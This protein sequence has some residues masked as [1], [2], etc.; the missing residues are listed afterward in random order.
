MSEHS[1]EA[2]RGPRER[3]T[4]FAVGVVVILV[5]DFAVRLWSVSRW[6]WMLDDW[7]YMD[8]ASTMGLV[9]YLFQNYNGHIMPGE[10]LLVRVL[11]AIAPLDHGV[12]VDV[13]A[14]GATAAAAVWAV[15]LRELC[16]P[17]LRTLVPLALVTLTPIQLQATIWWAAALQ[18][19]SIQ[20][21]LGGCVYFATR[22][23]RDGRTRDRVGLLL[24]FAAGLLMWEKVLLL[25]IP[26]AVLLVYLAPAVPG[27][28]RRLGRE[29]GLLAAVAA[30]YAVLFLVLTL[31]PPN[32]ANPT[33][34]SWPTWDVVARWYGRLVG[35]LLSPGLLGG[36][37]GSL[38][39]AADVQASPPGWQVVAATALVAGGVVLAVRRCRAAWLPLVMVLVYAVASWGLVVAT[40]LDVLGLT[41]V[42][43][44]R[45]AIDTFMVLCLAVAMLLS[46]EAARVREPVAGSPGSEGRRGTALE[47]VL[48]VA[49]L[50][51]LV[52]A[53]VA[54]VQRIGTAPAKPWLDAVLEELDGLD[55]A[56]IVDEYAPSDVLY[57]PFWGDAALLSNILSPLGDRV[58]FDGPGDRLYF[59]S[60]EGRLVP[61]RLVPAA[62]AEPGPDPKCGYALTPGKTVVVPMTT[63]LYDYRWGLQLNAFTSTSGVLQVE[64]GNRTVPFEVSPGL[65]AP[66][67]VVVGAID[68]VRVTADLA[69]GVV[70]LTDVIVGPIEPTSG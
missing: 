60:E 57:Q 68:E 43:Y 69:D 16:G 62:H 18:T 67:A 24:T 29:L 20:A 12:A 64:A 51:S 11:T 49:T 65:N 55:D 59:L 44:E 56:M 36:P 13:T 3:I 47:L 21:A 41:R 45:Y 39:T 2:A 63:A 50:V 48:V 52:A 66:M 70:C 23:A 37:W 5:L 7:V 40:R 19:I 22:L 32:T 30:A 34:W 17:R 8:R 61:S 6:T 58:G 4:P 15:A 28:L 53:N 42:G 31:R 46:P 10:F 54:A 38:P 26:L 33:V 14:L 35:D 25:V 9:G 1:R 27:R